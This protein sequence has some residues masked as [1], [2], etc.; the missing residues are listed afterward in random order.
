MR[1]DR[2]AFQDLVYDH[3]KSVA[4]EARKSEERQ[5]QLQRVIEEKDLRIHRLEQELQDVR[6]EL[7]KSN[8]LE[9]ARR[10]RA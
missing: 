10:K 9:D 1:R 7:S 4:D 3:F 6:G 5:A 2:A 8:S